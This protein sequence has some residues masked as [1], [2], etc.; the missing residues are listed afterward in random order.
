MNRWFIVA[1]GWLAQGIQFGIVYSVGVFNL[2][3]HDAF[4]ESN[5]A[6]SLISSL[7]SAVF[8]FTG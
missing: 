1:G 2:L 8:Y 6:I 5:A 3:F 4:D 7:I